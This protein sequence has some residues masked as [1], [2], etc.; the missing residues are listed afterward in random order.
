MI[1]RF[2]PSVNHVLSTETTIAL[3]DYTREIRVWIET[4][5]ISY[6]APLVQ[7]KLDGSL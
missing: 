1:N 3:R 2:L 5:L 6:P 4:A 7:K